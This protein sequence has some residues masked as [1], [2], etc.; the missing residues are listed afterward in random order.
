MSVSFTVKSR[1]DSL[2]CEKWKEME[3]TYGMTV[4]LVS[5][6][7]KEKKKKKKKVMPEMSS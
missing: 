4:E 6:Y 7:I 3:S 1:L 2:K 5:K